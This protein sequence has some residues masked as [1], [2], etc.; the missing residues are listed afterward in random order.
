MNT[1]IKP[2]LD[3]LQKTTGIHFLYLPD[4]IVRVQIAKFRQIFAIGK[5]LPQRTIDISDMSPRKI[6]KV[7]FGIPILPDSKNSLIW[8]AYQSGI[9]VTYRLFVENYDEFW[10]PLLG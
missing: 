1:I 2:R 7:L 5:E 8:M 10:H 3:L 6:K 9:L 4:D